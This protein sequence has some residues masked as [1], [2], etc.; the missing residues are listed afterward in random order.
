M[1]RSRGTSSLDDT[2][3]KESNATT[4]ITSLGRLEVFYRSHKTSLN[5]SA[6]VYTTGIS[7]SVKV[8]KAS[9]MGIKHAQTE[10][11]SFRKSNKS[12]PPYIYICVY[13][14]VCVGRDIVV[15]DRITCVART[16]LM[17]ISGRRLGWKGKRAFV[18]ELTRPWI[19]RFP[20]W[21]RRSPRNRLNTIVWEE[22]PASF[23]TPPDKRS[24]VSGVPDFLTQFC[25]NWPH[26]TCRN[27][28]FVAL[29][30]CREIWRPKVLGIQWCEP[31]FIQWIKNYIAWLNYFIFID[32]SFCM[33]IL[34]SY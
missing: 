24:L 6:H 12:W 31:L 11:S 30:E 28:L 23:R 34:V 25:R 1:L 7:L 27:E 22:T 3:H 9:R 5:K 2:R 26:L 16:A 13:V 32:H 17:R 4:F 15:R 8:R 20:P 29:L 21:T 14:Y 19:S 33:Y 10:L 18:L